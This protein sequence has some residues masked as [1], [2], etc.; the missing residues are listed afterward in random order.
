MVNTVILD[1]GGVIA[2]EGWAKGVRLIAEMNDFEPESFFK[3]LNALLIETGYMLGGCTEEIWWEAMNKKY[4]LKT[5]PAQMKEIIF[6]LFQ[7][8]GYVIE[9]IKQIKEKGYKLVIL[10]DQVNWLDEL[11]E[12]DNF[13]QYFD[14]VFNS[15]YEGDCKNNPEY[16]VKIVGKLGVKAEET[17]FIDDNAGHI[18]R[19]GS[20]GMN[21]IHYNDFSI[22]KDK[23]QKFIS[24]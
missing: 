10:S 14:T 21:A 15:Y 20:T 1:F 17:V 13:F 12:R 2:D 24:I 9:L 11:N 3:E 6:G 16:F 7:V 4:E 5:T 8:R 19:A 18:E 23:L 22:V